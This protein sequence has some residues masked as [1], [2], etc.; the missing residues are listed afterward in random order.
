MWLSSRYVAPMPLAGPLRRKMPL[1]R[2]IVTKMKPSRLRSLLLTLIAVLIVA[3]A[4]PAYASDTLVLSLSEFWQRGLEYNEGLSARE[5]TLSSDTADVRSLYG[6]YF[7][8]LSAQ[9]SYTYLDVIPTA[10]IPFIGNQPHDMLGTLNARQSVYDGGRRFWQIRQKNATLRRDS[11]LLAQARLDLKLET[12]LRYHR[13]QLLDAELAVLA[14]NRAGAEAQLELTRLLAQAGKVSSVEV[15]RHEAA[16]ID[17]ESRIA[18]SLADRDA[19]ARSLCLLA[20][21]PAETVLRPADSL[22]EMPAEAA[23]TDPLATADSNNPSL[24]AWTAQVSQARAAVGIARSAQLPNVS[25]QAWYG[26]E[27][28]TAGFS[29]DDNRRYG[30]GLGANVPLFDGLRTNNDVR[31]AELR[32]RSVESDAGYYRAGLQVRIQN[33]IGTLA[34]TTEQLTSARHA[35]ELARLNLSMAM[36]EYQAGRRSSTDVLQLRTNLLESQLRLT[37]LLGQQADLTVT[38]RHLMGIL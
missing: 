4:A 25:L 32:R 30:I 7:P 6:G 35:V 21:L 3:A 5:L 9:A 15:G 8:E 34:A 11:T 20:G 26:W 38:A 12:A 31:A 10:K 17:V 1:Y 16:L 36:A 23:P 19:A 2:R 22:S 29:F 24:R 33:T 18:G 37:R 13:L 27:F 14:E 28:G